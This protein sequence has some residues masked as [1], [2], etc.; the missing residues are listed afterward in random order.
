M[1]VATVLIGGDFEGTL[2]ELEARLRGDTIFGRQIDKLLSFNNA[3]Q[4][5]LRRLKK[6]RPDRI[7]HRKSDGRA[8]W[9]VKQ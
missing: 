9:M 6:A 5:Y 7:F 2:S 3:L 1:V 8:F 4:T